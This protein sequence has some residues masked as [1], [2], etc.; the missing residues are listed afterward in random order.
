MSSS[1]LKL[2]WL[3]VVQHQYVN[4]NRLEQ[5]AVLAQQIRAG[6]ASKKVFTFL[7]SQLYHLAYLP[8]C[9]AKVMKP[10]VK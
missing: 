4:D 5:M 9:T 3:L 2:P 10:V 1:E 6:R 7:M 8:V